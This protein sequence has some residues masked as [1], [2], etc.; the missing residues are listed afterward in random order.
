MISEKRGRCESLH[1]STSTIDADILQG[2]TEVGRPL[3]IIGHSMGGVVIAKV[4][5]KSRPSP[6]LL[7]NQTLCM[8]RARSEFESILTCTVGCLFFGAPFRGTNMAK[9][10]LL[11]SSVFGIEAYESLLSF[12]R[13]EKNDA[14]DEVTHD[15]MEICSK[16]TPPIDLFCAYEQVPTDVS[17]S[18]R[19]TDAAPRLLQHKFFRAGTKAILDLGG[20][21]FK[22]GTV[23]LIC[24]QW[25]E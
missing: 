8:A 13:A 24:R 14:L 22:S 11:Y 25:H 9:I 10:A 21:A 18:Q 16:L 7:M 17:Y 3:I 5:T 19:M 4:R 20:A 2:T 12:M 15:F 23:S 6:Q 1:Y